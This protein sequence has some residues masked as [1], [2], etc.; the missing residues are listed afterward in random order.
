LWPAPQ[1]WDGPNQWPGPPDGV[2]DGSPQHADLLDG[3]A[4][5]LT[6]PKDARTG[7][8]FQRVVTLEDNSSVLHVHATMADIDTKPR[9]WGIWSVT[10]LDASDRNGKNFNPEFWTY[11]PVNPKSRYPNGFKTLYGSATN[12]EFQYDAPARMVRA[13]YE[14][15]V[16][17]I[18]MDSNAGWV[19]SVDGE[20]GFV[21]VQTFG[22]SDRDYP[23][24]SSVEYWSYGLGKILAFGKE[25]T[26]PES[27][28]E[29]PYVAE[30]EL[31][32][33]F[34]HLQPG[35][36]YSFDYDWRSANIG[37]NY[38]IVEC[39]SYGC[40]SEKFAVLP[41]HGSSIRFAGRFA[42]FYI[43]E[44]SLEFLDGAGRVIGKDIRKAVTPEMA[45]LPGQAFSEVVSP[46]MAT[47]AI[48]YMSDHTGKKLGELGRASVG[49]V[50]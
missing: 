13:H 10:E 17:K 6:S 14:R 45:F 41:A 27:V 24:D 34:A 37:G 29:N 20:T 1:G 31:I 38:P 2:L 28:A 15:Q 44:I 33:P 26:Q 32:S 12:R 16:G 4:V 11:L 42:V 50:R 43:G 19:A 8:Q 21:F 40:T 25:V 9:S 3:P 39:F 5:R 22:H 23:D 30:T 46:P 49:H 7:I 18:G 48:L 36:T 35:E 47:T